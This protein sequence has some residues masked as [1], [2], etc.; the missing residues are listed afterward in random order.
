MPMNSIECVLEGRRSNNSM[1]CLCVGGV[2]LIGM[3]RT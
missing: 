1:G 2:G 3:T